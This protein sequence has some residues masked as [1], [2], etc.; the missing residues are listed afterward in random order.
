[1]LQKLDNFLASSWVDPDEPEDIKRL[2][3]HELPPMGN[4][5][6]VFYA[7]FNLFWAGENIQVCRLTAQKRVMPLKELCTVMGSLL[8]RHAARLTKWKLDDTVFLLETL[9]L[10]FKQGKVESN[11][12]FI[13]VT[14]KA[15]VAIDKVQSYIDAIL[16]WSDLDQVCDLRPPLNET[17][18]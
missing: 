12:E 13:A 1:M 14:E 3:Q 15:L 18:K 17:A 9:S 5:P 2:R 16:P 4:M 10:F 11:E 8:E 6:C 7:N